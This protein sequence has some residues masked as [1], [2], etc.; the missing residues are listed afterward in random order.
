MRTRKRTSSC[1]HFF[2][3]KTFVLL[4][5]DIDTTL[6]VYKFTSVFFR[7]ARGSG[8]TCLSK[9]YL[10]YLMFEYFFQFIKATPRRFDHDFA[11]SLTNFVLNDVTLEVKDINYKIFVISWWHFVGIYLSNLFRDTLLDHIWRVQLRAQIRPNTLF[12]LCSNVKLKS[13][14]GFLIMGL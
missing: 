7:K 13:A 3:P 4:T 1:F 2:I 14:G 9:S 11:S 10:Q 8:K 12:Y 5:A 6:A